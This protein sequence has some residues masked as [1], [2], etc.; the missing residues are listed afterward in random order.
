MLPGSYYRAVK[1]GTQA[2]SSKFLNFPL[3]ANVLTLPQS[4]PPADKG[5]RPKAQGQLRDFFL[6][7]C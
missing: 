7:S 3:Q 6:F 2:R 5:L 1:T 4:P